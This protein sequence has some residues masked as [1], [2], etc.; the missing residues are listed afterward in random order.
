MGWVDGE[1]LYLEPAAAYRAAQRMAGE[2]AG[3]PVS[4]A[5]LRRRIRDV[6][7]LR[8]QDMRRQKLTVRRQLQ[9]SRREVLCVA[10]S[11]LRDAPDD[12]E[13]EVPGW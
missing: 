7:L 9:G 5:T 3:V 13:Q 11:W 12:Q 6:G 1:R 2:G 4:E 10:A 8:E